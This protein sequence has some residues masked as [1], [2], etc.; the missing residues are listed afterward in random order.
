MNGTDLDAADITAIS[1]STDTI[2]LT[3]A[4][5]A[6]VAAGEAVTV[7][8]EG[9]G[10]NDITDASGNAAVN[11]LSDITPTAIT[12][13]SD[14]DLIRPVLAFSDTTNTKVATSGTSITLKFSEELSAVTDDAARVHSSL[15]Q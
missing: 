5:G 6:K 8:Y 1:Q 14:Q 2:T 10:A 7:A 15:L 4:D 11:K 13:S 9:D 12:N 3:L